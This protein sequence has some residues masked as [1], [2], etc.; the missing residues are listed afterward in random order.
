MAANYKVITLC[1]S[2][3]QR[4]ILG[5]AE[6]SANRKQCHIHVSLFDHSGDIEVWENLDEGAQVLTKEM[7][8]DIHK[9]K[10]YKWIRFLPS[11]LAAISVPAQGSK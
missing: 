3:L 7:L 2:A 10:F 9:Q 1:G 5:S 11:M 4:C 8:D 6:T